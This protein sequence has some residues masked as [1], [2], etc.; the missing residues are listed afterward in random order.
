M[1]VRNIFAMARANHYITSPLPIVR[2][3][4]IISSKYLCS[5]I[6]KKKTHTHLGHKAFI[7][8]SAIFASLYYIAL[9]CGRNDLQHATHKHCTV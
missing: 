2:R 7:W 9:Y 6:Y 4:R 5:L 8:N 1:Y 3:R